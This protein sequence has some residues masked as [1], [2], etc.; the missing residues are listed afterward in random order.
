MA[1]TGPDEREPLIGWLRSEREGRK[2]GDD[3]TSH[4]R[5]FIFLSV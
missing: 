5:Q 2:T 4:L 1:P 3:G